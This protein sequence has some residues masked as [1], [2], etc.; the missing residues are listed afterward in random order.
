MKTFAK[1]VSVLELA[2]I[3]G[4]VA[5]LCAV[6]FP[7][8]Q[9]FVKRTKVSEL[10]RA[11]AAC[12]QSVSRQYLDGT[13]S[14]PSANGWGC[15]AGPGTPKP[16]APSRHVYSVTTSADG[17]IFVTARNFGDSE[18]DAKVLTLTPLAAADQPAQFMHDAGRPLFGWRCGSKADHTTIDARYLPRSCRG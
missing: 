17:A 1:G 6:A 5:M 16:R 14:P 10:V 18:I 8:Y 3:I 2:A 12:G 9:E 15:E 4:I 7:A 11:A 13:A